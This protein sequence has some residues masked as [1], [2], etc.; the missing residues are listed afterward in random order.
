MTA[1]ENKKA[2]EAKIEMAKKLDASKRKKMVQH[3]IIQK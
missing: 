3:Q 2:K 1:E